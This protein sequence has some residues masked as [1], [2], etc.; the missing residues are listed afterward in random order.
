MLQ[1]S[2]QMPAGAGPV[3]APRDLTLEIN[4]SHPTILNLNTIRKH[5]PQFAK[6]ISQ[7]FLDQVL[8]SS[9]IPFDAKDSLDRNKIMINDYLEATLAKHGS[10]QEATRRTVTEASFEP[11]T[12]AEKPSKEDVE[13]ILSQAHRETRKANPQ[14][15]KKIVGEYQV[16]GKERTG[17][18]RKI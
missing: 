8:T 16:T 2:G 4:P 13:S 3:E 18:G 11:E 7:I 6:E 17:G 1:T 14:V 9:S 12:P 10:G 5:D 15:E